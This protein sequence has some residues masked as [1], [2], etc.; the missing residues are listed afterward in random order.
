LTK[1]EIKR[2][3]REIERYLDDDQESDS[4]VRS[5][6]ILNSTYPVK[7]RKTLKVPIRLEKYNEDLATGENDE[8][9][10]EL[11]DLSAEDILEFMKV[12]EESRRHVFEAEREKEK[13]EIKYQVNHIFIHLSYM[14]LL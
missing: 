14:I 10:N 3:I 12:I 4:S 1:N 6:E 2:D 11:D 9:S 5:S 7:P 8:E 13:L